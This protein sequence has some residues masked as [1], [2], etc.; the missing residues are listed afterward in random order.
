MEDNNCSIEVNV[1]G[2]TF[3]IAGSE[4]FVDKQLKELLTF[5]SDNHVASNHLTKSE[6]SLVSSMGSMSEEKIVDIQ[7]KKEAIYQK[8]INNGII[9]IDED[10]KTIRIHAKVTGDA[11]AEKARNIA[12]IY[13]LVRD[14]AYVNKEI[15]D[16][17]QNFN[18]YDSGNFATSIKK[19]IVNFITKGEGQAWTIKLTFNG[20]ENAIKVLD[21]M[22]SNAN[23]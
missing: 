1:M 14:E 10:D 7:P 2:G 17:C 20:K 21:E 5:F 22:M 6:K 16:L 18:C 19:D 9:S 11:T 13:G 8:Y 15:I 12:L 23:K 4:F 3:A